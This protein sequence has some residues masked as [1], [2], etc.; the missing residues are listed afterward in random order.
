M[1]NRVLIV[2]GVFVILFAILMTI[3]NPFSDDV[4][5]SQPFQNKVGV[6]DVQEAFDFNGT[7]TASLDND[8]KMTAVIVNNTIEIQW[9]T[10]DTKAL[11]WKG[12]FNT[13]VGASWDTNFVVTSQGDTG[14]METSLMA[15][16]DSTKK[17]TYN[18]KTLNYELRMMGVTRT[19]RLTK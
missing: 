8:A 12:T 16:Q 17:F 18:G 4:E 15:S 13:P 1:R 6:S 7:W 11:Y 5:A 10:E 14:T 19:V 9:D 2:S 3:L